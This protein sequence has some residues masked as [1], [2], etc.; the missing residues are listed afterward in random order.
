MKALKKGLAVAAVL[1]AACVGTPSAARASAVSFE[2]LPNSTV[3]FVSNILPGSFTETFSGTFSYDTATNLPSAV[4]ITVSGAVNTTFHYSF[5]LFGNDSHDF[6]V[7]AVGTDNN[8]GILAYLQF[9][10]P[11]DGS[12]SP[13]SFAGAALYNTADGNLFATSVSG[14][15]QVAVPEPSTWEMIILGFAGIGFMAYRN[16]YKRARNGV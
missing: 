4:D 14:G 15:V 9:L 16:R 11:L 5:K 1:S 3:N 2:F 6:G 13:D 10:N 8:G 7:S 12:V